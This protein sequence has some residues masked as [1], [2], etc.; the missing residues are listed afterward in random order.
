MRSSGKLFIGRKRHRIQFSSTNAKAGPKC[1]SFCAHSSSGFFCLSRKRITTR[2]LPPGGKRGGERGSAFFKGKGDEE[3]RKKSLVTSSDLDSDRTAPHV[4]SDATGEFPNE[5]REK[6]KL[7][8][9]FFCSVRMYFNALMQLMALF[10]LV[11]DKI[12]FYLLILQA[13]FAV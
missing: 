6:I 9:R 10:F 7:E 5:F 12:F 3:K 8:I 11:C 2:N 13:L 1:R 4:N